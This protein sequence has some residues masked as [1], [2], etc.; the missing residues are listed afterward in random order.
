M[1]D[2]ADSEELDVA[3]EDRWLRVVRCGDGPVDVVFEAGGG[4]GS[5]DWLAVQQLLPEVTSWSYDRAGEGASP[6]D[7]DWSLEASVRDLQA[8]LAAV[9]VRQPAV[10]VGHSLGCHI[11]RAYVAENPAAASAMLLVDARPP[12]FEETVLSAGI[13]I[14]MPP[15]ESSIVRGIT[16]ADDVVSG[17]RLPSGVTTTVV[18]SERFDAAP[19]ELTESETD[20]V[21]ALW[22]ETQ[23][24]LARSTGQAPM[25]VAPDTGHQIAAEA[26]GY[27]ASVIRN[28]IDNRSRADHA[29]PVAPAVSRSTSPSVTADRRENPRSPQRRTSDVRSYDVLVVGGGIAGASIA[30][31]LAADRSVCLLEAES[32]LASHTTG[33][34]AATFI[35]SLGSSQ[36]R[37]LTKSSRA[38]YE[39]PPAPFTAPL[40]TPLPLLLTA[41]PE[42]AE[43]LRSMHAQTSVLT[44]D[45]RIVDEGE[46]RELNPLLRPGYPKLALLEPS[47]M[48]IDVHAV[49][50]G[51]V[52]GFRQRNGVVRRSA[53]LISAAR[54]GSLWTL[55]DTAGESYQAPVLVN[56]AGAWAD[57]VARVAGAHP[58]GIR[59]LLRTIF[60]VDA[61]TGTDISDL[62]LTADVEETFYFKREGPRLL[63]SPADETP[64]PP[65]DA[66]PDALAV[67]SGLET[68]N[69][70]TTLA[71]RHV[72]G[73]WAGLRSFAPDRHPVV[74]F[75]A[76]ADGMFWFA[77]QGGFGIQTAPALAR[78]GAS[79]LR[80]TNVPD[81]LMANGVLVE[82][83]AATRF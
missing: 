60:M 20:Q 50:Q 16:H 27:L 36:I 38:F 10:F 33:R 56:A 14:S 23:D 21:A 51:Y 37:G 28:A 71:A 41:G 15:P 53:R 43:T 76:Q 66:R 5:G 77:G 2:A 25:L 75:D 34:S 52:R 49:H 7:G 26:P 19:G 54:H 35:E 74:G 13:A 30:Y 47:A 6:S 4:R 68:I 31:E 62:P 58:V 18:C 24:R 55:S 80:G 59:P 32:T 81:D 29:D 9:G 17:L 1:H 63:C 61:P 82:Q 67:A 48:E 40:L 8:W 57:V 70:V 44:P 22:R 65:S 39:C 83:M 45:V 3:I 69:E 79:L 42:Q 11:I 78:L 72:R 64:T 46:A 12:R 73:S